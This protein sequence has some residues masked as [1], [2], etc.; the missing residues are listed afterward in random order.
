MHYLFFN[1]P[2]LHP[3]SGQADLNRCLA[4]NKV[5]FVD[6]QFVA[7]GADSYWA[8]CVGLGS[9]HTEKA[10]IAKRP[11]VD[12]RELLVPDVFERYERMRHFR[13][14]LA[15]KENTVPYS[16]FNNEQLAKIAEQ[17]QPTLETIQQIDGIGEKRIALYGELFLAFLAGE[18]ESS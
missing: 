7:A 16:I 4:T 11:K 2:V 15:E 6:R 18:D 5:K 14:Q 3:E 12:Y 8:F 10:P 1:V 13:N 17:P 9:N